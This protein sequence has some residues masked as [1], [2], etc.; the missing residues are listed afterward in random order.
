M[1]ITDRISTT[2][3][4]TTCAHCCTNVCADTGIRMIVKLDFIFEP[5]LVGMAVITLHEARG[6]H[7]AEQGSSVSDSVRASSGAQLHPYVAVELGEKYKKRGAA[8][9][10]LYEATSIVRCCMCCCHAHA[11]S[12]AI[13]ACVML[14]LEVA[15]IKAYVRLL[16]SAA[17]RFCCAL[18]RSYIGFCRHSS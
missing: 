7:S 11:G 18:L 15:D 4:A 3:A 17:V 8:V 6:L 12:A 13:I 1:H 9:R 10:L 16:R 14:D 5:S 2:D